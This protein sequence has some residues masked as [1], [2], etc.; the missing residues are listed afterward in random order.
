MSSGTSWLVRLFTNLLSFSEWVLLN[1]LLLLILVMHAFVVVQELN[2][3]LPKKCTACGS[4]CDKKI[5][6]GQLVPKP[7]LCWPQLSWSYIWWIR[8][9]FQSLHGISLKIPS[10]FG[11]SMCLKTCQQRTFDS[12]SLGIGVCYG[13]GHILFTNVHTFLSCL[14]WS[15]LVTT[16]QFY[17]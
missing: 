6:A 3:V 12:N 14:Y 1:Y 2:Y 13:C 4:L 15:V 5:V 9:A 17:T 11:F 10:I 8:W 16:D 7:V